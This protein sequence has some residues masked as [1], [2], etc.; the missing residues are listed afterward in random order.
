[1]ENDFGLFAI[2]CCF[3]ALF[4]FMFQHGKA[5][6]ILLQSVNGMKNRIRRVTP[7]P[8]AGQKDHRQAAVFLNGKTAFQDKTIEYRQRPKTCP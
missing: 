4:F 8:F 3:T 1:M 7:V 5:N 6:V 2:T